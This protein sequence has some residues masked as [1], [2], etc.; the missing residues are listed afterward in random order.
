[1]AKWIAMEKARAGLRHEVVCPNVMGRTKEKIGQSKRVRAGS[2]A[3]VD[4]P[5]VARTCILR[6]LCFANAMFCFCSVFLFFAF[7][8]SMTPRSIVLDALRQ[9]HDV[10]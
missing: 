5:R 10:R 3:I 8:G 2:L 7:I 1:M 4:K 6:A 9:P